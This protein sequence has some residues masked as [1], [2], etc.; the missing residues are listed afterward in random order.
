M[1]IGGDL[2]EGPLGG[3]I[4]ALGVG[5]L[6]GVERER[7]AGASAPHTPAGVRTFALV[8]VLGA[9]AGTIASVPLLAV[10][11]AAV[12]LLATAAYVRVSVQ[13]PGLTTEVALVLTFA[14]GVL[15]TKQP[16]LAAGLGVLV[17]LLLASR[18]WIHD[19]VRR[20]LSDREVLD[21][22]LLAAAAL[23]VLPL[24]PDRAIDPYGVVNPQVV[25]RLTVVVLLINAAGYVALRTLGAAA[26]FAVAGFFGGFVSSS[27]TIG[28]LGGRARRDATLL[29]AAIAGATLSSVATVLQ[30]ALVLSIASPR[31]L[32]LLTPA[33]VM[34]GLVA[35][36]YGAL[37]TW[38]AA[39]KSQEV[40]ALPGRAFEPKH[41]L[42]F[43][44][45]V[46]VVLLLAAFLADRYGTR[47]AVSGIALAGFADTHSASASAAG[48]LT[49][50]SISEP[51]AL[52]AVL[53]A[54]TTNTLT[55][56]LLAL[57]TGGWN[58]ARALWPGLALM[59]LAFAAGAWLTPGA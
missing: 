17:A 32:G 27:A 52:L 23:I 34:A 28:A 58:Y 6:I 33:L 55:K 30:L 50:G 53:L 4:V 7:S 12:A 13:D 24:L 5:L 40:E 10:L 31:L 2:L 14:I 49:A 3:F 26:G 39:V 21:G 56:A 29:R 11:G 35:I 43:A 19:V 25:W 9:T 47:G 41:A 44:L 22:I 48:L 18:S 1:E 59:L 42:A 8:A 45:M 38:L 46:T 57:A 15:A 20:R 36:A 16:Q 51:A 37:F 54:F